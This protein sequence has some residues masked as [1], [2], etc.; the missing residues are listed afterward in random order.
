MERFMQ[1]GKSWWNAGIV[2][3]RRGD[4]LLMGAA[5]AYNSPESSI[6]GDQVVIVVVS[7]LV[8]LW[9]GS[10][11]V[12]A[13]QK[14]L[15]LVQGVTDDRGYLK[16]RGTGIVVT[17][18]GGASI[19]LGYALLLLGE[20]AWERIAD[21]LNLPDIGTVQIIFS[22]LAFAWIFGLLYIIYRLGPPKPVDLPAVTA[23]VVTVVLVLGTQLAVRIAPG[24]DSQALAIFGTMGVLLVWLY[25]VG[26]VVV[27]VPMMVGATRAAVAD[28]NQH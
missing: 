16:T 12:Y 18:A 17:V 10:R 26:I 2:M 28:L 15:R 6:V 1:F 23:G 20:S 8:A 9:S 7:I 5:I 14:S 27:A 19:M 24:I 22:M 3:Y 25:G 13:I 4:P 11:A 21:L